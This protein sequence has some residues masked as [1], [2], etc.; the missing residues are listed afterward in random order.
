MLK[1][2]KATNEGKLIN[3]NIS[4]PKRPAK[5]YKQDL[6]AEARK[7]Q[8]KD[9]VNRCIEFKGEPVMMVQ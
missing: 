2:V 1:S 8:L 4:S 7:K 6:I 9:R 5:V 3:L